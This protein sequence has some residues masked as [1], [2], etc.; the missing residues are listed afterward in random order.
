[1]K[2]IKVLTINQAGHDDRNYLVPANL[3]SGA[4]YLL[5]KFHL[6][7]PEEDFALAM[8][9]MFKGQEEG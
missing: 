7:I 8:K 2:M 5:G 3:I 4:L 9:N 6:T 1:M